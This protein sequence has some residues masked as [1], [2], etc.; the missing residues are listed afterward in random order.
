MPSEHFD[1]LVLTGRP[2]I[3]RAGSASGLDEFRRDEGRL[4]IELAQVDGGGEGVLVS[5]GSLAKRFARLHGIDAV[6]WIVHAVTCAKPNLKLRRVLDR[7]GFVVRTVEGIE[8]AYYFLDEGIGGGRVCHA[9][10]N[11]EGDASLLP[12]GSVEPR[13][14]WS[15]ESKKFAACRN[16]AL[17]LPEFD[18]EESAEDQW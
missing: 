2:I 15:V 13:A 1:V 9:G 7:R 14:G 18:F 4:I 16:D 8:E 5:L 10:T 12:G 3:F 6:E 11:D 17:V